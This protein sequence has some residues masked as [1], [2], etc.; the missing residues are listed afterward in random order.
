[1]VFNLAL[2]LT[3]AIA[4]L[5]YPGIFFMMAGESALLPIPSEIV[6]PFA[7]F[8]IY[9]GKMSFWLVTI[10]AIFGQIFGSIVAYW[11]GYY[12]GRPL[13]LNYGKHVL[14][15]RK[16]FERVGG[17]FTKYGAIAIFF[18][19]LMPLVRTIIS[20]PAGIAR[21]NFRKFLVFSVAGIIP[22]TILLIYMGFKLGEFWISAIGFF[23]KFQ[24]LVVIFA[25][26]LIGWWIWKARNED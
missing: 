20:F 13:V 18:T 25:L 15:N 26:S 17:W 23:S 19:R 21:M 5:G 12:G 1:M 6:L 8:L 11:I 16:R 22:W 4:K 3:D 10:I 7:G 14:L 24:L 9:S 2:F